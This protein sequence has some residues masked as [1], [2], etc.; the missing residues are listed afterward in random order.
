MDKSAKHRDLM[1]FADGELEGEAKAKL[2]RQ[3]AEQPDDA[4]ALLHQQQLRDAVAKSIDSQTPVMPE[5]LRRRIAALAEPTPQTPADTAPIARLGFVG[6]WMPAAVAAALLIG[7]VVVLNI[8]MRLDQ[9]QPATPSAGS[10]F[11]SSIMDMHLINDEAI[12]RFTKRHKTCATTPSS[13]MA[14]DWPDSLERLPGA[15]SQHLGTQANAVMDLTA[16]GYQYAGAGPCH[17]PGD[18]SAH[19]VY[20][21]DTSDGR[22]ESISLWISPDDGRYDIPEQQIYR[23]SDPTAE[24]PVLLW[25]NDGVIYYIVADAPL[26]GEKACGQLLSQCR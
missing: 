15:I 18:K 20:H 12:D 25:R 13:L 14:S 21:R 19:L 1:A 3:L 7:A 22:R 8:M 2:L 26:D 6:R 11:A 10:Q 9:P 17:T 23:V 16:L 24:H 5:D 4:R